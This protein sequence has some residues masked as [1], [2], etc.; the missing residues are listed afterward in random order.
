MKKTQNKWNKH[1]SLPTNFEP[2]AWYTYPLQVTAGWYFSIVTYIQSKKKK[3]SKNMTC[4]SLQSCDMPSTI[5]ISASGSEQSWHKMM[6]Q[7][8]KISEKAQKRW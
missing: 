5:I 8:K 4:K 7:V 3:K 2:D 1:S 6:V